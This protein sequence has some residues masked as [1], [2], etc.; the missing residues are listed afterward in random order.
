MCVDFPFERKVRLDFPF[1]LS[2]TCTIPLP[3]PQAEEGA[4]STGPM[5][6][7]LT[8]GGRQAQNCDRFRESLLRSL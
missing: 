1:E 7:A 4:A 6:L 5:A 3:T 8:L 2:T